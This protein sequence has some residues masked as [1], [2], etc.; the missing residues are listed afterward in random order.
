M[1][2][3]IF[4]FTFYALDMEQTSPKLIAEFGK[5]EAI[6]FSDKDLEDENWEKAWENISIIS[7]IIGN[8]NIS[9]HFPMDNCDYINS[10]FV[11]NKLLDAIKRA[12]KL[13]IQ[14]IVLHP[15][16]RYK[17]GEWQYIDRLKMQ[18]KL[19]S[20]IK[21]IDKGN[22]ELCLENMPAI[23]NKYDDADSAIL[24]ETDIKDDINYTWDI[25]HYFNVVKTM[26]LACKD[27]KWK[28]I[29]P[30][31]RE[32]K[33]LDFIK[34]LKNI[35]HYHFS[36]FETIAN[37]FTNQIC[38]E[39]ILPSE[40]CVEE[41]YYKEALKFIYDDAIKNDKSIIFEVS[42]EDYYKRINIFKMLEWAKKVIKEESQN[43]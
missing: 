13:G 42:E 18:N 32:C 20:F 11:K 19:F 26:I 35:K 21:N 30:D 23:G 24:F 15:N 22:V 5:I 37:P 38:R 12:N 33:Y 27:N 9:F 7:D 43:G 36:A 39:G 8:K 1:F 6:L 31:I 17:I 29:L 2:N 25:C 28:K 4:G 41:K 10:E 40:G 16:L 14:K 3:N 34:N